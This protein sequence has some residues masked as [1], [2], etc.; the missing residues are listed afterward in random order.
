MENLRE[1]PRD[2]V[3]FDVVLRRNG[4]NRHVPVRTRIRR[5]GLVRS[6]T[7]EATHRIFVSTTVCIGPVRKEVELSLVDRGRML[8]RML[9]GRTA[10]SGPFL[11]D[12][13]RRMVLGGARRKKKKSVH[14]RP[15]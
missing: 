2:H 9:L 8:H 1:L 14:E 3:S 6:S 11:I 4:R 10:L 5:R 13:D 12:V 15:G 7:G